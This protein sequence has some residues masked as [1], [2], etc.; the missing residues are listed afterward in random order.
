[1]TRFGR[2]GPPW[3]SV[4]L[5]MRFHIW[6]IDILGLRNSQLAGLAGPS[7]SYIL[8]K[9]SH[10]FRVGRLVRNCSQII[11]DCMKALP[12]SLL[13]GVALA[14]LDLQSP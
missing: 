8:S 6:C 5:S 14:D 9:A 3:L 2:R 12:L 11:H 13:A 7:R 1:M 4:E 10:A